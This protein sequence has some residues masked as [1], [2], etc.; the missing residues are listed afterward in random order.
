M[1]QIPTVV[2]TNITLERDENKNE[3]W[4]Q[5]GLFSKGSCETAKERGEKSKGVREMRE[6]HTN[7]FI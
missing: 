3:N 7:Q 6:Q 4:F 1:N 5:R 2:N